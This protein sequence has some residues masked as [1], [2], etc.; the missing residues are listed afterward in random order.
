[1]GLIRPFIGLIGVILGVGLLLFAGLTMAFWPEKYVEWGE[2]SGLTDR[3]ENR[4]MRRFND[5]PPRV[6]GILDIIGVLT[7]CVLPVRMV[8][9]ASVK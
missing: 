2:Q 9:E 1:M 3:V 6:G 7:I 5:W 8:F 4:P